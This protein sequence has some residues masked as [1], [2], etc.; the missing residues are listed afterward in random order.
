MIRMTSGPT[1]L[2]LTTPMTTFTG[3]TKESIASE[4]QVA[5]NNFIKGTKRDASVYPIF[6]NDLYYDTSRR[7]FLATIKPQAMMLLIQI[8]ILMMDINMKFN[9]SWRNY[10]LCILSWLLLFKLTK[11]ENWSRSL[12][13]MQGPFSQ[14]STITILS[15]IL[16]NMKL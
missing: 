16:H 15:Q 12:K 9:Y 10:L 5:L 7:S 3:C 13:E 14:S 1:S 2:D 4:T 11:E 8:L 6:K